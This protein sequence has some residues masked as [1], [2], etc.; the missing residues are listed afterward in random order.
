[1]SKNQ[2]PLTAKD[3]AAIKPSIQVT[4]GCHCQA[5]RFKANVDPN[6]VILNCNCSICKMNRFQH[7]IVK[8]Q[9]FNLIHGEHQLSNYR[10]NTKQA[11]HLFCQ[12]CDIKS[13][14]QPRSHPN[15]WSINANCIDDFNPNE[16]N[17]MNFD[18]VNWEQAKKDLD[19]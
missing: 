1:M 16:W 9:N 15:S 8:H 2:E 7:L 10:F 4:G 11:K 3:K 6:S 5:I 12:S 13:F 18:G 14:Y 17:F 19:T